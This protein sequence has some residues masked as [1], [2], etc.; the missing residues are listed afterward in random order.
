MLGAGTLRSLEDFG[1]AEGFGAAE[2]FDEAGPALLSPEKKTAS[3]RCAFL[4]IDIP[5]PPPQAI[6]VGVD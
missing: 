6:Q 4:R 2:T 3:A 5:T 1:E